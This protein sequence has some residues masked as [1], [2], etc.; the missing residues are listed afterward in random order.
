MALRLWLVYQTRAAGALHFAGCDLLAGRSLKGREPRFGDL[1]PSNWGIIVSS[2]LPVII[3][4][5][6]G[7]EL[8]NGAGEEMENPQRDVPRSLIRAGLTAAI[9]YIAFIVVILLALPKDQLSNVRQVSLVTSKLLPP[10]FPLHWPRY[11][12]GS[13]RWPL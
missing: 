8:Q 9:A 6:V 12:A 11:W 2:I 4:Q 10:Y 5:Y 7:F 3:F 13:L 1:I